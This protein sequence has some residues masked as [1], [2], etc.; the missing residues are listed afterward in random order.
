MCEETSKTFRGIVFAATPFVSE[1]P[2]ALV[3]AT[4]F[5]VVEYYIIGFQ[6]TS[7][8]KG[9][10]FVKVF[11]TEILGITLRSMIA[12]FCKSVF[13]SSL[14]IPVVMM[15]LALTAGVVMPPQ[16]LGNPLFYT[17]L[18]NVNPLRVCRMPPL[19]LLDACPY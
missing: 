10:F 15:I 14:F 9:Y 19:I 7:T 17:F 4:V 11:F 18:C 13:V 12:S 8:R 5:F 16:N 2:N 3:T 1:L 6:T